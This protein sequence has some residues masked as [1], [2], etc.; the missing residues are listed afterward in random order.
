[1]RIGWLTATRFCSAIH[2]SN[3]GENP[4]V[5]AFG[6]LERP[7][8][9][10]V[11]LSAVLSARS[12]YSVVD[13]P[14]AFAVASTADLRSASMRSDICVASAIPIGTANVYLSQSRTI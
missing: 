5:A 6:R 7:H 11:V 14:C 4:G 13:M 8:V 12:M 10:H 1:M 3:C 9:L 2:A